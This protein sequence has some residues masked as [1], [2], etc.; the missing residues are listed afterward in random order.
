MYYLQL[1]TRFY[2]LHTRDQKHKHNC[3]RKCDTRF[4]YIYIFTDLPEY[5]AAAAA[6][7]QPTQHQILIHL[8]FFP[9]RKVGIV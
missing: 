4:Q 3:H 6:I 1:V 5:P 9:I 7:Y 2:T 8:N